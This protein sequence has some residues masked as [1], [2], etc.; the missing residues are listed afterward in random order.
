[1][2]IFKASPCGTVYFNDG[3]IDTHENFW[4]DLYTECLHHIEVAYIEF[5][6]WQ[7]VELEDFG[8]SKN[9]LDLLLVHKDNY[10]CSFTTNIYGSQ[11]HINE[12]NMSFLQRRLTPQWL[13]TPD[14]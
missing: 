4:S 3:S 7:L 10:E 12:S 11:T 6:C 8:F 13:N 14:I 1:M 2:A 5:E 9:T